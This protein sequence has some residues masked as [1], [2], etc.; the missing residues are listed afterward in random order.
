MIIIFLLFLLQIV[1]CALTSHLAHSA[2]VV[3]VGDA[4]AGKTSLLKALASEPFCQ[5]ENATIGLDLKVV[6]MHSSSHNTHINVALWDT[7]GQERFKS[8]TPLTA[9]GADIILAVFDM[10]SYS[11]MERVVTEWAEIVPELS[12]HRDCKVILVGTKEDL[13]VKRIESGEMGIFL[14]TDDVEHFCKEHHFDGSIVVSSK[15]DYNIQRLSSM[16]ADLAIES[17]IVRMKK[18]ETTALNSVQKA[19]NTD[20]SCC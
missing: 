4:A 12:A 17:T 18:Q 13:I 5:H 1:N 8:I 14:D 19:S 10:D 6:R 9:R 15:T 2:K 7:A 11:L 16:I 3:L 20:S